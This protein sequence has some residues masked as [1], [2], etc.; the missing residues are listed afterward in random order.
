MEGWF[1]QVTDVL[2]R[3]AEGIRARLLRLS[4]SKVGTTVLEEATCRG[5]WVQGGVGTAL[6]GLLS[7]APRLVLFSSMGC[8]YGTGVAVPQILP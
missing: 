2:P 8:V 3:G 7:I 5:V 4:P 6:L 1:L